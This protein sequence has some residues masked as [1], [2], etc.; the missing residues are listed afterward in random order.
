MINAM[1]SVLTQQSVLPKFLVC[2][3]LRPS[4]SLQPLSLLALFL[5]SGTSRPASS[6]PPVE[7]GVFSGL[8][9]MKTLKHW[10]VVPTAL[11]MLLSSAGLAR[12]QPIQIA[13]GFPTDPLVVNGTSGGSTRSQSCGMISGQPNHVLTLNGNFNYLRINVQSSGQ[14]TLLIKG[15]SG[16]SCVPA[17]SLSGG[18]IQ[19]PGYWEQ[20]IYSIYIGDMAGGQNPYTLSITQK[21]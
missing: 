12:S 16:T 21:P 18:N 1:A 15:P 5:G 14:P 3:I 20:G 19:S 6:R 13:P 11:A 8:N 2:N 4:G 17:D 10:M 7:Y 9:F